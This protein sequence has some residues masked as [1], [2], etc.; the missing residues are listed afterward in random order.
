MKKDIKT[1]EIVK[2]KSDLYGKVLYVVSITVAVII[3]VTLYLGFALAS[4]FNLND[5]G[6]SFVYI[7]FMLSLFVFLA[8]TFKCL[9]KLVQEYKEIALIIVMAIAFIY[10]VARMK[11]VPFKFEYEDFATALLIL[12]SCWEIIFE[13]RNKVK[14]YEDDMKLNS[15]CRKKYSGDY[16][17]VVLEQWKTCVEMANS[18]TEKRTN[19][20]NIYITINAA[21]LAVISFSWDYKSIILS[22]IGMIICIAW[23]IS[24]G[25]YKKLSSVKY[26]IVNEI[27]CQLPLKPFTYEWKK[28]N[29][30][31]KYLRLTKIEK[32]LPWLFFVV[33]GISI[34][35]PAVKWLHTIMCSCHGG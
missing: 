3:V 23:I 15:V 25:S 27:E 7:S 20:N 31:S 28:L 6:N 5:Y 30:E 22:A 14:M 8:T 9:K 13:K 21:L 34:S 12:L 33:Y 1:K 24:I 10:M 18:N 26:H 11:Y 4:S 17:T 32:I 2:G 16:D 19:S 35:I 29:N